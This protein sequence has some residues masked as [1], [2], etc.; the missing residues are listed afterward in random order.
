[1]G[2]MNVDQ[3]VAQRLEK[4]NKRVAAAEKRNT[5]QN[6]RACHRKA[7]M[8]HGFIVVLLLVLLW[9][10][11]L[12]LKLMRDDDADSNY[13]WPFA[14]TAIG[15]VGLLQ[16]MI[17]HGVSTL[18]C[19][20]KVHWNTI[21]IGNLVNGVVFCWI[22]WVILALTVEDAGVFPWPLI[23]TLFAFVVGCITT[24]ASCFF[25]PEHDDVYH[26]T[27]SSEPESESDL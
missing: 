19:L 4:A 24:L 12:G 8:F 2:T 9:A 3:I 20:C 18:P 6:R 25:C 11:Y 22:A 17:A 27:S 21:V 7:L 5:P 1:M 16:S 23:V 15:S 13:P 10:I 14:V 26:D